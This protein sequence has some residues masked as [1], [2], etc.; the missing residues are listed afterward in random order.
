MSD[1]PPPTAP[2]PRL[3]LTRDEAAAAIGMSLDS[4]E[5]HVQ[6]TMRLVRLG[7]M[8]LVPVTELESWLNEHARPTLDE[9]NKSAPAPLE[10]PGA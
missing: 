8:R 10:R 2:I 9:S 7:R 6:P 5:R 4:F 1:R 3:A